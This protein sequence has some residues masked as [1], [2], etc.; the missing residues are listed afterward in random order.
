LIV[1]TT[2]GSVDVVLTDVVVAPGTE[3][4]VV[5]G[6]ATAVG[7]L[8]SEQATPDALVITTNATIARLRL[9][10]SERWLRNRSAAGNARDLE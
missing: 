9:P 1:T 10:R 3:R 4:D 7:V 6:A 2:G 5:L 8:E